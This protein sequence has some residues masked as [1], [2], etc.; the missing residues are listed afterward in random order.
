MRHPDLCCIIV[1]ILAGSF[2]DAHLFVTQLYLRKLDFTVRY[3]GSFW[4]FLR[5]HL[6]FEMHYTLICAVIV[7]ILAGSFRDAH[8]FVVAAQLS[9]NC[10]G[11]WFWSISI[12]FIL[13]LFGP[14]LDI[15][16]CHLFSLSLRGFRTYQNWNTIFVFFL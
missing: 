8:L 10:E 12:Y 16:K 3:F 2:R 1:L 4:T 14:F 6:G 5:G 9:D 11:T 13:G 7:L 15:S